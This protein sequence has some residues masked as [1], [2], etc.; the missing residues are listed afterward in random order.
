MLINIIPDFNPKGC[1]ISAI[2]MFIL[3]VFIIIALT[4]CNGKLAYEKPVYKYDTCDVV[5]L[6]PDSALAIIHYK[7]EGYEIPVYGVITLSSPK[8][9]LQVY[10]YLIFDKKV[11]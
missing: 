8:V 10:E 6:K 2:L 4:G 3:F 9:E 5:Y 7:M 11:K 1:L